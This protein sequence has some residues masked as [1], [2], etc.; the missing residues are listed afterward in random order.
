M[1]PTSPTAPP[2]VPSLVRDPLAI[3]A[4]GDVA[5]SFRGAS[6]LIA[7]RDAA[8]WIEVILDP[9]F[10]LDAV[11]GEADGLS[12]AILDAVVDGSVDSDEIVAL[13]SVAFVA[14][15]GYDW[16]V[17]CRLVQ[18]VA[19]SA[20]VAVGHLLTEGLYARGRGL[21]EWVAAALLLLLRAMEPKDT[22]LFLARLDRAPSW[23]SRSEQVM[24][25]SAFE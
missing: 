7:Y 20:D 4:P 2:A 3:L 5:I 9:G 23:V 22:H 21:G 6:Y 15:C 16:W 11:L 18:S 8:T 12:E 13:A 24:D 25:R 17:V 19:A 10:T 1:A 14:I